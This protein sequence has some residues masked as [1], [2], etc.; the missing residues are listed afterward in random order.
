[1][2]LLFGNNKKSRFMLSLLFLG[3]VCIFY[4]YF[5]SYSFVFV[6]GLPFILSV[7]NP[8][9]HFKTKATTVA[10]TMHL[11]H[12]VGIKTFVTGGI[13][14][15]HRGGQDSMDISADLQELANTPVVVVS[16]GIKSILDIRRTL[17]MLETLSVPTVTY[18]SNEFPAFFSPRSGIPTPTRVDTINDIARA[19]QTSI[20]LGLPC[21]MLV[22][23]PNQDPVLGERTENAIQDAIRD[24]NQ[25]GIQG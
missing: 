21:G 20:D 2:I 16:A 22:A 4:I 9:H 11:A 7:I 10:S 13:G 19:Y 5:Q 12:L 15:V 25:L 6:Y 14:G 3:V 8:C 23:I 18:Q 17:E 24:A 1:M